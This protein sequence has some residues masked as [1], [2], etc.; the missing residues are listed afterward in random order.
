LEE[1]GKRGRRQEERHAGVLG[2]RTET[3]LVLAEFVGY[4]GE[5]PRAA[6]L[7]VFAGVHEE[8]CACAIGGLGLVEGGERGERKWNGNSNMFSLVQ[9]YAQREH[10]CTREPRQAGRQAGRQTDRQADRQT[11][12]QADRQADRQT[13]RQAETSPTPKHAWPKR[14]ACWS[15][16][17]P[18]MGTPSRTGT[19]LM[20]AKS[21]ELK[22][23]MDGSMGAGMSS[24]CKQY[25][26][27]CSCEPREGERERR[28]EGVHRVL[29][30]AKQGLR[31]KKGR[32]ERLATLGRGSAH[33]NVKRTNLLN[34]HE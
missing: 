33:G 12:R 31:T 22:L 14:A 30:Q 32:E 23:Q 3:H 9:R 10:C 27:H 16:N 5:E 19:L 24:S 1:E 20:D 6:R 34:I 11:G 15:P 26:S 8:E 29:S 17:T 28:R 7:A 13:G 2:E 21:P 18:Q 4:G 25:A